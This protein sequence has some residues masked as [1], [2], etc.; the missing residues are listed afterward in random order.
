MSEAARDLP[1]TIEAYQKA[2][3]R[4]DIEA[5]LV[6]FSAEAVVH[7]ENRDW[8]GEEQIR[9]W[10]TK[11]SNEYRY[12]RTLLDARLLAPDRWLVRNRLEGN[13]PGSVVDLRY[14]FTLDGEKI[15]ELLIAP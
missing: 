7:D 5:A 3:D 8:V 6:T 9:N 14:E 11:T 2:H 15:S 4:H 13:F 12:T 1:P 10:L